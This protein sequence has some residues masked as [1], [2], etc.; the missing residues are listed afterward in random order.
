[1]IRN[2]KSESSPL[3][4]V[5]AQSARRVHGPKSPSLRQSRRMAHLPKMSNTRPYSTL[6]TRD[7]PKKSVPSL[8][9]SRPS[10]RPASVPSKLH[11]IPIRTRPEMKPGTSVQMWLNTPSRKKKGS[12]E[13]I[14]SDLPELDKQAVKE[15]RRLKYLWQA[16]SPMSRRRQIQKHYGNGR[17]AFALR[18]SL[19]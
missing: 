15:R 8:V 10:K 18:D 7:E 19:W 1:M 12:R 2:D 17:C 4:P 3:H 9:A 14:P 5:P 16:A 11:L 13:E 6:S